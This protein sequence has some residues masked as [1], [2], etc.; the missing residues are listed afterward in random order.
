MG[1]DGGQWQ[2]HGGIATRAPF[3]A[4]HDVQVSCRRLKGLILTLILLSKALG[5]SYR[6][7]LLKS[8]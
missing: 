2:R 4:A 3:S 6:I 1:T 7:K 5:S 8:D